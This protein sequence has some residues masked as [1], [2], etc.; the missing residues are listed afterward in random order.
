MLEASLAMTT[1]I[2]SVEI[3]SLTIDF[4]LA[5]PFTMTAAALIPARSRVRSRPT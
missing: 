3:R 4:P 1:I 2:N 5:V